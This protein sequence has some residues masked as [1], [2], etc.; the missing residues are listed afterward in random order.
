M[1][2][3]HSLSSL[4]SY[5]FFCAQDNDSVDKFCIEKKVSVVLTQAYAR[6]LVAIPYLGFLFLK[7]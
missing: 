1:K 4:S 3:V 7:N 2:S 5:I 6:M